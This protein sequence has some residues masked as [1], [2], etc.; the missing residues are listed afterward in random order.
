MKVGSIIGICIVIA[1]PVLGAI[2]SGGKSATTATTQQETLSPNQQRLVDL[3]FTTREARAVLVSGTRAEI[4][5]D[6][7]V[8]GMVSFKQRWDAMRSGAV[9]CKDQSNDPVIVMAC[10]DVKNANTIGQAFEEALKAKDRMLG[11][12]K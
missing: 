9:K 1:L 8:A 2:G 3:G 11:I 5:E 6:V 7:M 10:L 12:R 4:D